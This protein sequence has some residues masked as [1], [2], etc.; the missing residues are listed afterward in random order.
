MTDFNDADVSG[1]DEFV[2]ARLA[3]DEERVRAGKLPYIDEAERRGWLR[4]MPARGE[5]GRDGLLLA[6]GPLETAEERRP[7]PFAEKVEF[8][9]K[10][11]LGSHDDDSVKLI[12]S[13]YQ[14]HP[15]WREAWRH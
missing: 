11:I 1:L 5:D 15:L 8:L 9:R 13:V 12:A 4:I 10:E 3:E 2:L 7:V 14:A 6:A